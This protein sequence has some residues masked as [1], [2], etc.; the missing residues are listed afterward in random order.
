MRKSAEFGKVEGG[1]NNSL[2]GGVSNGEVNITTA[3][4]SNK[5]T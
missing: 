5:L 2:G 3:A 4:F 1:K